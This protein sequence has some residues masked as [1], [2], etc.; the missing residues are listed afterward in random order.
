MKTLTGTIMTALALLLA[1]QQLAAQQLPTRTDLDRTITASADFVQ[2][3]DRSLPTDLQFH[4]ERGDTVRLGDFFGAGP[5]G[6][7]FSYY[8]C[9]NLCP[10]QVRNLA[11]RL[12]QTSAGAAEQAQMLVVSIDPLDSPV[13]AAQAKHKFLDNLLPAARAERWHFLS[14]AP[15]DIAYLTESVGFSYGYDQKTHQYAHP[16]GFVLIT[17]AGKIARYF[18]GF[19]Y[20]AD[21][22]GRAFDQAAA[23]QIASPIARLLMVCFHYDLASA[24]YSALIIE[25]LRVASV[26]MLLGLLA[27]AWILL[28]RARRARTSEA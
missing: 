19:D 20:T 6:L 3:L 7:V 4:D 28:R 12:A 11:Q 1:A 16:A 8:G 25:V 10:M 26:V 23:H 18:F 21:E 13:S 2:H 22:L 15:A 17:S 24:P 9:S 27:L 14:G 5:L